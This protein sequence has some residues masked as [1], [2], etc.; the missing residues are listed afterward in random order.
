MPTDETPFLIFW[1]QTNA[2]LEKAGSFELGFGDARS[3]FD[4]KITPEETARR[5][6]EF[7]RS[8]VEERK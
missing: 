7:R 5:I 6:I 8:E 4:A 2:L 1:R 3:W